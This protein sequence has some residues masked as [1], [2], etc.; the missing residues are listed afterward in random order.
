[1]Y[2]L[3]PLYRIE[4]IYNGDG[5][6]QQNTIYNFVVYIH[7]QIH[8]LTMLSSKDHGKFCQSCNYIYREREIITNPHKNLLLQ[9][10]YYRKAPL[11]STKRSL[12]PNERASL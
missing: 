1:M 4:I 8:I 10:L 5:F 9:Y 6:L 3:C 7:Q 11:Y 12:I 2:R